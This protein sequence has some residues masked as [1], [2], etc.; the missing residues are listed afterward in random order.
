MRKSVVRLAAR[1]LAVPPSPLGN[2]TTLTSRH[3]STLIS[4]QCTTLTSRYWITLCAVSMKKHVATASHAPAW[5]GAQY[6]SC[7]TPHDM[8]RPRQARARRAM[9]SC[10]RCCAVAERRN[11]V[12]QRAAADSWRRPLPEA[13]GGQGGQ[14]RAPQSRRRPCS[15]ALA[16]RPCAR[17]GMRQDAR[18]ARSLQGPRS[19]A[20]SCPTTN[21]ASLRAAPPLLSC[22]A[23]APLLTG[24]QCPTHSPADNL[25]GVNVG[26]LHAPQLVAVGL[27]VARRRHPREDG[28]PAP[29]PPPP[30]VQTRGMANTTGEAER[31]APSRCSGG[32]VRLACTSVG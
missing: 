24:A 13:P 3:C 15:A 12:R 29:P 6:T 2:C 27:H 28:V 21:S 7:S 5:F 25:H 11:Q 8:Q 30:H 10:P 14:G 16:R 26:Q 19:A 1:P 4:R 31:A 9:D 23:A 32:A 22:W 18:R 20:R 17:A